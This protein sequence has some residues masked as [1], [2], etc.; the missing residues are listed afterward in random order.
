MKQFDNKKFKKVRTKNDWSCEVIAFRLHTVGIKASYGTV[1][2]WETGRTI[3]DANE[4]IAL[5]EVLKIDPDG[6]YTEAKRG[7]VAAAVVVA[8]LLSGGAAHAEINMRAIA[9]I[10]SSN[11]PKA[12][13]KDG[14]VGLYQISP[15]CLK[16]FNE[17]HGTRIVRSDLFDTA[18][19]ERIARWYFSWLKGTYKFDDV[20]AIIAYNGGASRAL[21]YQKTGEIVPVT[22]RYLTKYQ[23]FVAEGGVK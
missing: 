2:N 15:I 14:G 5:A 9:M 19:N 17:V 6:L 22:Q 10:E 1:R 8:L 11:N 18:V 7:R 16:H 23:A 12:V 21:R 3:P 4:V 13:A 20:E